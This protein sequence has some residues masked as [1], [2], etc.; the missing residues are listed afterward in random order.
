MIHVFIK[1]SIVMFLDKI[2][3]FPGIL[4]KI[5]LALGG[6][7]KLRCGNS[8]SKTYSTSQRNNY[9]APII[10]YFSNSVKH[11]FILETII[12]LSPQSC[13]FFPMI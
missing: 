9:L 5:M 8:L 11:Q 12:S 10:I 4:M 13:H 2:S 1:L 3:T 7:W 6:F